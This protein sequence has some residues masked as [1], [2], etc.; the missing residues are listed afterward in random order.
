VIED[1]EDVRELVCMVLE[2]SGYRV[3]SAENGERALAIARHYAG[4]IDLVLTDVVMPGQG[5]LEVAEALVQECPSLRVLY[6]SGYTSDVVLRHGVR[7]ALVNFLPKPFTPE[8]LT[9]KVRSV[10]DAVAK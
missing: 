1:E 8:E 3:L 6:S 2:T 4:I 7:E 9:E 5:G 10:L